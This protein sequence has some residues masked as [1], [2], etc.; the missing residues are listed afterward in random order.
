MHISQWLGAPLYFYDKD[1][2]YAW[3]ALIKQ[4]FTL[5]VVTTQAWWSPTLVRISGDESVRGQ[6]R[7]TSD[8][9]LELDFPERIVLLANHQ[10]CLPSIRRV[11][12]LA[13][14]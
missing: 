14:H 10:V 4:H 3:Q 7:K 2:Y 8:G 9:R 6:L 1:L 5:L 11:S 12:A 13:D